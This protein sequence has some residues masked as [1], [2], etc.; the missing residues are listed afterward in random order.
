MD[1]TIETL[2]TAIKDYRL[3]MLKIMRENVKLIRGNL[4]V[5]CAP[6]A[7]YGKYID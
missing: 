3:I 5:L 7:E 6:P 2:Q 1:S 4:C